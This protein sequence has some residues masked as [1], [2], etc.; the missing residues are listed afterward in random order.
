MTP[1]TPNTWCVDFD[2]TICRTR[3]DGVRWA[4]GKAIPGMVEAVNR[5]GETHEI[6]IFTSRPFSEWEEMSEWLSIHRVK[7]NQI[8][9]KPLAAHYVDDRAMK[10]EEFRTIFTE[11]K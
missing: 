9:S 8:Q 2:N 11:P 3:W 6:I 1:E 4:M 7:F 5:C 10:P